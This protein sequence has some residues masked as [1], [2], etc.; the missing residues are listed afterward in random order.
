MCTTTGLL[1]Q[2]FGLKLGS[3]SPFHHTSWLVMVDLC[4]VGAK[5]F[6]DTV[7]KIL[8]HRN[9]F[10]F[11]CLALC[12]SVKS[13]QLDFIKTSVTGCGRL[14]DARVIGCGWTCIKLITVNMT[15]QSVP[16]SLVSTTV[17]FSWLTTTKTWVSF[18][19]SCCGFCCLCY[20][21]CAVALLCV[22]WPSILV[23][24]R[25]MQQVLS[26]SWD[27]RSWAQ[28]CG[29]CCASFRGGLGLGPHLTQR[30]LGRGLPPYQVVSWSI[31]PFGHNIHGP[32]SGAA[33]P[34]FFG[35]ELFTHLTQHGLG[36][37]LTPYQVASW[38]IQP[39]GYNTPTSWTEQTDSGPIA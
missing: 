39:F 36:Q 26:S 21:S 23:V 9:L 2:R 27:G 30:R 4:H 25:F 5:L 15:C 7:Y 20:E 13:H 8:C 33:V 6:Y 37:G 28:K 18:L 31:Q 14:R 29:G 32:K 10:G 3:G 22:S 38:S 24:S 16:L 35:G 19:N 1:C 17:V 11:C 12:I 34:S